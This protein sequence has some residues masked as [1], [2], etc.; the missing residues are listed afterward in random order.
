MSGTPGCCRGKDCTPDTCMKLPEGK[1]CGACVLFGRCK[2]LIGVAPDDTIC[3]FHP[4]K[5]RENTPTKI[6]EKR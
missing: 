4:R 3:D 5:F 2:V 1:T 6:E